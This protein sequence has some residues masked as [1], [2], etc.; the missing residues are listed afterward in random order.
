MLTEEEFSVFQNQLIELGQ[1]NFRLKEQ[2]DDLLAKNA[3]LPKLKK[4]LEECEK[5]R[6]EMRATH[7]QSIQ[8]LK[9]ELAKLQKKASE[10]AEANSKKITDKITEV[11]QQITEVT[12]QTKEKEDQIEQLRQTVRTHDLRVQQKTQKLEQLQKRAKGY[13][14]LIEFLRNSRAIP[15]YIEDLNMKILNLTQLKAKDDKTLSELDQ[16]VTD[17]HR[18]NDELGKK[19]KDKAAEIEAA[20]IKLKATSLRIQNAND[21]IQKTKKSLEEA[22]QRL[23]QTKEATKKAAEEREAQLKKIECEKKELEGQIEEREKTRNELQAKLDEMKNETN[24]EL[25]KHTTKIQELRKKLNSIKETG[26]DDEIPRVDRE[27]QFQINRVMEEKAALKD[28]TQMLQQAILLVEEEIRDKDVE[29]QTLTL[30]MPPTPRIVSMPEFQQKQLLLEELV[31]Q[32]RELRNT[33]SEMTERIVQLKKENAEL[34]EKIK[35]KTAKK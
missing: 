15:M 17:L 26:D 24:Q 11:N 21:E 18:L 16:Q 25:E 22:T 6:E 8:V 20:N 5:Q 3:E 33:F 29:I 1:E 23:E 30:K 2:L 34:R 12:R 27:L 4:E 13:E 28:K 19:I 9:E 7:T 35:V 10:Q 14:P 31:L 32:N